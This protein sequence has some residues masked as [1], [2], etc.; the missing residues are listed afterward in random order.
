ME[1]N[2]ENARTK[3]W[4]QPERTNSKVFA[5]ILKERGEDEEVV[6][7]ALVCLMSADGAIDKDEYA[8]FEKFVADATGNSDIAVARQKAQEALDRV[9]A[10]SVEAIVKQCVDALKAL[11]GKPIVESF[12]EAL[13]VIAEADDDGSWDEASMLESFKNAVEGDE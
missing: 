12:V 1:K 5:S 8:A 13:D 11:R 10:S 2:T 3:P 6:I 4:T 7:L 9:K